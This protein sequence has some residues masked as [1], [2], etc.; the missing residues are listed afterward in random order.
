MHYN[1]TILHIRA[2]SPQLAGIERWLGG[3]RHAGEFLACW[4]AD[5]GNINQIMLIHGYRDGE[6]LQADRRAMLH[7]GKSYGIPDSLTGVSMRAC[8]P[9]SGSP[10][11]EPGKKGPV[12]E[13]RTYVMMHDSLEEGF[14]SWADAIPGRSAVSKP[15]VLMATNDGPA[16]GLI[17]IWPYRSV[18]ERS[19]IRREVIAKGVWPPKNG[20]R[21]IAT[22]QS[23]IF[24]PA[25]FS[26]LT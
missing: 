8:T 9:I 4:Y 5:I 13:V 15:L 2:G 7:D 14:K 26:P 23:D 21:Y 11:I 3:A 17:H 24:L 19:A 18:D 22:Q 1:V 12:Y 6:T 10:L 16:T 25:S 20:P